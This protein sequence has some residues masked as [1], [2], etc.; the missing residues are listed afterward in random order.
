M[1][2][3]EVALIKEDIRSASILTEESS[4]IVII[5]RDLYNRSI[6]FLL[7]KDF[8]EK[9]DFVNEHPHFQLLA[10]RYKK[11]M[12][13][14]LQKKTILYDSLLQRQGDDAEAIYYILTLAKLIFPINHA[15]LYNNCYAT[16]YH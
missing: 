3:G 11:Q 6:K 1:Q 15:T 10:P 4:D 8:A 14:A 12:A 5:H 9:T 2:F 7:E 16:I 13:M